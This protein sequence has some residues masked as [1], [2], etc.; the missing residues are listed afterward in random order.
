MILLITY[1]LKGQKDYS[2]FY[3]VLK[4]AST[5]WHYL[6]STWLVKTEDTPT[7]WLNKLKPHIHEVS[8]SLFIVEIN[9]NY[10]GWLPEKA[11]EWIRQNI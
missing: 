6:D 4:S 1:D 2:G 8:D 10:Q 7:M 3:E 5:W 11:Y 9:N